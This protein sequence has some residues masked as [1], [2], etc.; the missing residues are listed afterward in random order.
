MIEPPPAAR[1]SSATAWAAKNWCLKFT[2]HQAIEI[3]AGDVGHLVAAVVG[4]V[5]DQH[6]DRAE[7]RP[8]RG[9]RVGASAA[10]SVTS[11]TWKKTG[12]SAPSCVASALPAADVEV[13]ESDTGALRMEGAHQAFADAGG[14]AGN[15][16]GAVR[17]GRVASRRGVGR[18]CGHRE[19]LQ[20]S[21]PRSPRVAAVA[22][23]VN[24]NAASEL[25]GR[26]NEREP[27]TL[28][29]LSRFTA[30][31]AGAGGGRCHRR[32]VRRDDQPAN[33]STGCV[34]PPPRACAGAILSRWAAF[35]C[36]PGA[37]ASAPAGH[38]S[39]VARSPSPT[40]ASGRAF[41]RHPL[42]GIGWLRPWQVAEASPAGRGW[43]SGVEADAQWPWRFEASQMFDARSGRAA[44]QRSRCTNRD[45]APMP[46][47]IGHHPYFPH[48][49]GTRLQTRT[50]AMWR[51]DAEVMPVALEATRGGG[52]AARGR[53]AVAAGP[54]QQLHGL[55]RAA[56]IE[57]PEPSARAGAWRP[58]RRSI[59]SS[60]IARA[61]ATI[62]A[63][64]R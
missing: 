60:S 7:L 36:C 9:D 52:A 23:R 38:V 42:H 61:A 17:P 48:R 54:R 55:A 59:S 24:E 45:T 41:G 27:D 37:T 50:A 53:R 40:P 58:N 22:T 51:A 64:S 14:A 26:S 44:L 57:W 16:D 4:G 46:A 13:A 34:R 12:F 62:S 19:N 3:L 31:A 10:T 18:G 43:G 21:R 63:P 25:T 5:V 30:A 39:A 28:L 8:H 47:G 56:R 15:E 32:V 33:G 20:E 2:R 6:A 49:P 29:T 11:Q 1:M 35:R